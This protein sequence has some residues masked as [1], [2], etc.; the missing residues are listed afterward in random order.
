MRKAVTARAGAAKAVKL[1]RGRATGLALGVA[2][3]ALGGCAMDTDTHMGLQK[4]EL[5]QQ[6]QSRQVPTASLN[7]QALRL[8]GEHY[9]SAGEGP[10][11][12]VVTYD[13]H[14]SVNTASRAATEA[15]R[16]RKAL[17][18]RGVGPVESD[19]LPIAGQ[20]HVSQTMIG[21]NTYAISPPAGCVSMPGL[22]GRQTAAD[23]DY[24]VGCSLETQYARQIANPRDVA[25]RTGLDTA[26]GRRQSNIVGVYMAAKPLEPLDGLTTT[27]STQ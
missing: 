10:V 19:I 25:G 22:D 21:Y 27:D 26:D 5:S 3:L 7:D 20:G 15:G 16:I 8:L 11:E 2:L 17:E 24:R 14:S 4:M 6:A 13:P 9:R 23:L 18:A 12:L 1:S